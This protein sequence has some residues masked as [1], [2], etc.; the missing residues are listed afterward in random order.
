MLYLAKILAICQFIFHSYILTVSDLIR[1]NMVFK[2]SCLQMS[3]KIKVHKNFAKFTWKHYRPVT[4]KKVTLV[5]LFSC[6]F[7]KNL[8]NSF[9][10]EHPRT[11]AS[12]FFRLFYWFFCDSNMTNT[13]VC[14]NYFCQQER[15]LRRQNMMCIYEKKQHFLLS[16]Y[17][18]KGRES[19][20]I[21]IIQ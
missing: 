1:M 12:G 2:S 15:Y 11:T 3:Y 6:E 18:L 16:D 13:I 7:C 5:Q 14:I 4:I 17:S 19:S 10:T 9:F 8:K 20:P 21:W